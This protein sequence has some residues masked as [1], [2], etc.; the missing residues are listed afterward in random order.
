MRDIKAM[1]GATRKRKIDM[2]REIEAI[3]KKIRELRGEEEK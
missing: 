2:E 3:Q 1:N